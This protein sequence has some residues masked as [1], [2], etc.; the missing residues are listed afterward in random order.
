[1][2]DKI[3]IIR[4]ISKRWDWPRYAPLLHRNA[5]PFPPARRRGTVK[6]RKVIAGNAFFIIYLLSNKFEEI[7][8][9]ES[10]TIYIVR[11]F[12]L[13]VEDGIRTHDKKSSYSTHYQQVATATF[14]HLQIGLQ[15]RTQ[16]LLFEQRYTKICKQQNTK[17]LTRHAREEVNIPM[18]VS[19]KV[20]T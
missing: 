4:R 8:N 15:I 16:L 18:K 1:M 14:K 9:K 10:R 19:E 7:Y 17:Q 20:R 13:W 5:S 6:G 12:Y 3:R 2:Y 11:L